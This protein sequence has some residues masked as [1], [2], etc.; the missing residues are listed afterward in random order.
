MVD[1]GDNGNISQF[2]VPHFL[3]PPT[4]LWQNHSGPHLRW[5]AP[6]GACKCFVRRTKPWR[7]RNSL[8]PSILIPTGPHKMAH[9][10]GAIPWLSSLRLWPRIKISPQLYLAGPKRGPLSFASQPWNRPRGPNKGVPRPSP[11]AAGRVGRGGARERAQFSPSGGNGDKRT[12]RR[13]WGAPNGAYKRFV[14]R[15][16]PWRRRNLLPPSISIP[17]GP[18]K[19]AH[20]VGAIPW[21]SSLLLWPRTKISPQLLLGGPPKGPAFIYLEAME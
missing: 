6:N 12:L 16:K 18:Y 11:A 17:T 2:F 8:P 14:R 5:G 20:F 10:V 21:P 19:M 3:N 13:R 7:R 4:H 9:F 15:T 1:V